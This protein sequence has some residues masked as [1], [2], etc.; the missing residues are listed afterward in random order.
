MNRF[1]KQIIIALVCLLILV[2]VGVGIYLI[3]KP[4]LPTCDDGIQNQKETGVDCGGPCS[5]CLWQIREDFEIIFIEAVKTKDNYLD[6]VAK[7]KNPNQDW[8]A[9][10]F[11]YV[12][13]LYDSENNL[14]ISDKGTSYI[15]P[16]ETRYIIKQRVLAEAEISNVEFKVADIRWQE[17]TDYEEV[18]L[19]IKNP[20][21]KQTEALSQLTATLENISS[22]NLD[23]VDVYV[24]LFDKESKILGA[25]KTELRTILSKERRYFET[26][27]FFPIEE[28]VE[29]VDAAAKTNVF[30]DD[31]FMRDYG[32]E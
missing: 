27:W 1:L 22:Y 12:F 30:L 17:L 25:G 28:K 6:L 32:V 18:E 4:R 7:I 13:D 10:S 14:I 23:K 16:L 20:E 3:T 9:E 26:S 15:L 31:N 11:S 8:G 21:F 2:I 19:L 29:E 5:P 24:V